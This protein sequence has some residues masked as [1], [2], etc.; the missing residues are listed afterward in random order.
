VKVFKNRR[1][2][3][4][5]E[6]IRSAQVAV[7][8]KICPPTYSTED[9]PSIEEMLTTDY[10]STAVICKELNKPIIISELTSAIITAK[11]KSAPGLD[12]I[13]YSIIKYFPSECKRTFEHI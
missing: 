2:L 10:G 6:H 9:P 1:R 11:E 7:I 12:Q 3:I 4:P 13:E 5:A 8:N